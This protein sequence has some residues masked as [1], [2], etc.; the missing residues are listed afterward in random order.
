M[1][2]ALGREWQCGTIQLD[3]Q[4]PHNFGLTYQDADGAMSQPIVIHRA[5]FGSFERF[6]GIIIENF[7]GAFPFWIS[8]YQVGLVPIKP[9]HNDFTKELQ[10]KLEAAGVRVEADYA[11]R[12]MNEK[13]KFYKTMKDPY[14]VVI[15]DK[16]VESKTLSVTVRGQKEQLHNIP[17]DAFVEACK[18]LN[19]TRAQELDGTLNG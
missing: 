17:V 14:I 8:P 1:K 4:L 3:F 19:E 9:E 2:D 11:D 15:G 13:I 7:K 12:N 5:I 10:D 6:I 16:E 18:K